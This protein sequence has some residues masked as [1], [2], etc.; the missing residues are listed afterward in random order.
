[1][2][3]ITS[4]QGKINQPHDQPV[5]AYAGMRIGELLIK[6]GFLKEQEVARALSLQ[7]EEKALSE[8]PLGEI[9]VKKGFLSEAH[10]QELLEHPELKRSIGMS[11]VEKGLVPRERLETA[12]KRKPSGQLIGDFLVEEGLLGKEDLQQ[13]L[14]EQINAPRLGEL[15]VKL[16][17][18]SESDLE[19]ALKIQKSPRVLGEV[20]CDLKLINP[21]DLYFV[22]NKYKKQFKLGE[23]LLKLR[24]ID[25]DVLNKALQEQKHSSDSLGQILVRNRLITTEQLQEA[26]SK[27]SNIPFRTLKKFAYSEEDKKSLSGIVSQKYAE[28]NMMIPISL[29]GRELTV[30][31]MNPDKIHTARELKTLYN[32][33]NIS[34][35][36]IPEEKFSELFEVLYSK[37]LPGTYD[38]TDEGG[39]EEKE[40]PGMDFMQM[41]LDEDIEGE[42]E[43]P[44][45]DAQ[46]IEAEE[47]VNFIIKYGIG[48]G[49]SDIHL[50]QDRESVKLRYRIDGVLTDMNVKWLKK[51]L[52]E[53]VGS[54]VSR[55]KIISN[56]DIAERRLPQDGV[57]RINYY[58]KAKNQKTDLDFRVATCKGIVG[59]NVV[60]RI[61]DS[62]KANVG[63]EKLNH[64]P[65][66]LEPFKRILKSSA[67]M[68][69]VTGPTGSGKSSTLYGALR[70]IYNPTIKIITAEDPIEYNFPGVMQTQVNHKINLGFA[71]LM[72][73]FLRLDPDVILVGEMRDQ[74]T[75]RIGFDAAQTGHLVLSTLHTNDSVS[76]VSRLFDL[77]VERAQ[78]AACLSCVLA[79]RLVRRICPSCSQ[80]YLPEEEEWFLLFE[81]YPSHLQFYR[82]KG[83]EACN[84]TGYKGRSLLSEVFIVDK[85]I[86]K[87]LSNGLDVDEIKKLAIDKGMKTMLDDGLLKLKE[88][89]L[90]EIF[91]VIPHEMIQ[92]FRTR[93]SKIRGQEEAVRKAGFLLSDPNKEKEIIDRMHEKFLDAA[94]KTPSG[95]RVDP[96]LFSEFITKSFEEI[97]AEYRCRQVTF[98]IEDSRGKVDISAMP[99]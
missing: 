35:M 33:L 1:M 78:A 79:Q 81:E 27:Q 13:L 66:V 96:S 51:K 92:A 9:L 22:L 84:F 31:I 44:V 37:R 45:Y 99:A 69:L 29:A 93:A 40:A 76:S 73:S 25:K 8:L 60:I 75:A 42:K 80:E 50:E 15:A 56:L 95:K 88:T 5:A 49:A 3:M 70:Y 7:Q 52:Q 32:H 53:K 87:A 74:E 2:K 20:L 16:N 11:A 41:E 46:D 54:I 86:A 61:L 72:R 12:L 36:L 43:T 83:C 55:I 89:T 98:H 63:L 94:S 85:D 19:N 77:E 71:R 48:N 68:I 23:I 34:C 6:E 14:R 4:G 65:H 38:S 17:W 67:G 47:I 39:E 30:G 18:I 64:S 21:L 26:L 57:F 97:C 10:L 58:D 59:E 91:R 90:S 62:R 24:Y 28:K 82:G